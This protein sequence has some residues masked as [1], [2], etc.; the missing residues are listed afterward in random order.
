MKHGLF[1]NMV[2]YYP[3]AELHYAQKDHLDKNSIAYKCDGSLRYCHVNPFGRQAICR[4]CV[5]R[6]DDVI[7]KLNIKVITITP[8]S[9]EAYID[10]VAINR[11]ENAVMSSI[12]SIT[13]VSDRNDLNHTWTKVY[14]N[15]LRSSK[16][17]YN[18]FKQEFVSDL[19]ILY[20]F[21]GRFAWDGAA[22]SAAIISAKNFFVYDLKKTTSYYEFLNVSLHSIEE[23]HNRALLFY[24]KNPKKARE[25]AIEFIDSKI[26][27]IPTYERSYTELQQKNKISVDLNSTK[28]VIAIFPS[29]DDEYRFLSGEWGAEVVESQVKEIWD[30]VSNLDGSQFQIVVRM[31]PNMK[32]LAK[33][34]VG[35]YK[36]IANVF[37]GVF[38]LSPEDPTSTYT[39]IERS[40]I[41]ICF[42]STVAT[43]ANYMRKKV[44]NIGGS[45]YCKLP[46][47]HYVR[48]G[49]EAAE[50]INS[51]CLNLKPR[52]SSI[53]WFYYL[54]LYFD[55]NPYIA[56]PDEQRYQK[57][58]PFSFSIKSPYLL[59]LIQSLFRAE[60][61]LRKPAEKNLEYYRRFFRAILDILFNKF[62]IKL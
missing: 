43:E 30:L 51:S 32:G 22:R 54:W 29:S 28:K 56:T 18:F 48:S 13:R 40:S 47:A 23:N 19:D 15:L 24:A 21:N 44:I 35:A 16:N 49:K 9:N 14:F 52:R 61:E 6:A 57:K 37:Q 55:S 62:S 4:F 2:A 46:I 1:L 33:N 11:I 3:V 12:A 7:K 17:I 50:T 27:G 53:I 34:I 31:H 8:L 38:V 39:L 26:K 41:V 59:R 10:N 25:V 42:C 20:M 60:I 58:P 45:P 5:S 36:R